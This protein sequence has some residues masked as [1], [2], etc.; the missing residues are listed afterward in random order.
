MD[1]VTSW[2]LKLVGVG[3]VLVAVGLLM[4]ELAEGSLVRR[5]ARGMSDAG[6]KIM[7]FAVGDYLLIYTFE[8][9]FNGTLSYIQGT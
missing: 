5:L 9:V 6:W 7:L 3:A 4:R 2:L 8:A 1:V